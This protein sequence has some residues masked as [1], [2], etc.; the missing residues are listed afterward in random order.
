MKLIIG[1]GNPGNTYHNTRHNAGFLALDFWLKDESPAWQTKF[2]SEYFQTTRGNEKILVIKPQTFMNNSGTAAIQALNF[3]QLNPETD[4]LVVHDEVDIPFGQVK[5]SQNASSAGHNGVADI[6]E[7]LGSK[8]FFRL[9]LGVETRED[10]HLIPTD[11]F[12]L[13]NF[14]EPERTALQKEVLPAACKIID[15]F[16][17]GK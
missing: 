9:R 11:A 3:Y 17:S 1:L 7:K 6:I 5:L 15:Q 10:K 8:N 2:E 12:V 16:I 4:L 14:S 13:Q